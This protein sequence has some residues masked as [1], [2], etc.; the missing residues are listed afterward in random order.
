MASSDKREVE[1]AFSARLALMNERLYVS[2]VTGAA[3]NKVRSILS[4]AEEEV[5]LAIQSTGTYDIGEVINAQKSLQLAKNQAIDAMLLPEA[6]KKRNRKRKW[7]SL[8]PD[9]SV[10]HFEGMEMAIA[11]L[12]DG[13]VVVFTCNKERRTL[14]D[15]KKCTRKYAKAAS[16]ADE[17]DRY[18]TKVES[19]TEYTSI[20]DA[21]L[22]IVSIVEKNLWP[23]SGEPEP[24]KVWVTIIDGELCASTN[25]NGKGKKWSEWCKDY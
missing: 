10:T 18:V 2:S 24:I 1:P 21:L 22:G 25:L 16:T 11:S 3:M 14:S 13:Q 20:W 6:N 5:L 9:A 19:N 8:N 7:Q 23:E 15:V 12:L 17:D 4:N